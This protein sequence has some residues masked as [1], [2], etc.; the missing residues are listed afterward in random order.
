MILKVESSAARS[1]FSF[2]RIYFNA[3]YCSKTGLL[4]DY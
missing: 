4:A 2:L 3:F 1:R